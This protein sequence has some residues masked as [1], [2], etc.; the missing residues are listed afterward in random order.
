MY[1]LFVHN[2][3]G[4]FSFEITSTNFVSDDCFRISR[5][6]IANLLDRQ[7]QALANFP[8][9]GAKEQKCKNADLALADGAAEKNRIGLKFAKAKVRFRAIANSASVSKYLR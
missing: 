5:V 2:T 1:S 4:Q 6:A 9:I 7:V 3:P 8:T